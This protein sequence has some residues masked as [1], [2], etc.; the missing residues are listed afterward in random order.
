MTNRSIT[1]YVHISRRRPAKHDMHVSTSVPLR[2]NARLLRNRF[3]HTSLVFQSL[4]STSIKHSWKHNATIAIAM[5][6]HR[7]NLSRKTATKRSGKRQLAGAP[8]K[9][10]AMSS[11][12]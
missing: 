5:E 3:R 1:R 8:R 4:L 10:G 9:K 6:I 11:G 2:P 7:N 12:R